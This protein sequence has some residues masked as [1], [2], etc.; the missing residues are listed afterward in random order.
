M[1]KGNVRAETHPSMY[2]E[3]IGLRTYLWAVLT[4]VVHSVCVE[5]LVV[6][7][8]RLREVLLYASTEIVVR[9]KVQGHRPGPATF[10]F[11]L[12]EAFSLVG[13]RK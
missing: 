1:G 5:L 3:E 10:N 2:S 11:W 12:V 7:S 4:V 13:S 9:Y 6:G 8:S